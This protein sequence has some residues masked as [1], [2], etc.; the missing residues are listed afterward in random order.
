M[1]HQFNLDVPVGRTLIF[2]ENPVLIYG[3]F[4]D[5]SGR[6]ARA[7][8]VRNGRSWHVCAVTERLDVQEYLKRRWPSASAHVGFAAE[9]ETGAG[10]RRL[11]IEAETE[12]GERVQ[13]AQRLLWMKEYRPRE[14]RLALPGDERE[15]PTEKDQRAPGVSA[16][17][18]IAFYL[19]QF[20]AIPENDRWWGTGF[21]EWTN[22]RSVQPLFPGHYQPHQPLSGLGYYDLNDAGVLEK[23]AKLARDAGIFGFCFYYY[24]FAGK[25]LLEMPLERMLASGK[26]DMPFCYCWANENWSRRWDGRDT[27][28]LIAQQHSPADDDAVIHDLMRAFRDSRYIRIGRRPFLLVYRPKLIPHARDMFARWR[29]LCR[30]EGIGEIYLAGVMGF[31]CAEPGS[32][33]LDAL[34]EFPPNQSHVQ[35]RPP[36]AAAVEGFS[37]N[38]FD[39][40]EARNNSLKWERFPFRLFRGVTPSWDNTARRKKSGTIFTASSP[41]VYATWLER[42]VDITKRA[43]PETERFLFINAWNEWAEGCHLEPD[44][45][46]G[47]AWLNATRQALCG[48]SQSAGSTPP[49]SPAV[50]VIS[51]DAA[52]AGAQVLLLNLLKEWKRR[53]PFP[54]KVICVGDGVLRPQ[55]ENLYPTFVL[56]DFSAE[57]ARH[58]VLHEFIRDPLRIIYSSTVVNGPLL[59]GLRHLGVPIVTHSHEL[60]KSIERWAPGEIMEATLKNSDY[61]LAGSNVVAAN[62]KAR[63]GVPEDRLEVVFDF[64]ELWDESR[65]PSPAEL[66][67]LKREMRIGDADVVVFG[68]GTT[69]WRK[70]PDLFF[71]AAVQACK[72][73]ACLKFIWIGGDSSLHRD[74][75]AVHGLA[76]RIQFIG[77]REQSRRYYYVGHIFALT[78]REDPCPLVALEA[79]DAGLPVVCFDQAG[80]IPQVLGDECGAV[81]PLE[82][83]NAVATAI[84]ALARSPARRQDLGR[85]ARQRVQRG[86][87]SVAAAAALEKIFDRV[88]ARPASVVNPTAPA[89]LVSVIVP[90]YNHAKYLPERLRSVAGQT[91]T[92]IEIILLDDAS[93]DDSVSILREFAAND[94]RARLVLNER[95]SGST[96]KQ[97]RKGMQE[98]RGKY[99]WIAESDDMAEPALLATLVARLERDPTVVIACCQLRMMDAQGAIGATPDE[100]L[101][102]IHP[103]R[104]KAD[105]INDGLDEIRRCMCKKNTVLNASGVVFRNFKGVD[106]LVHDSIRLCGDWLFW[107]RL[108]ARGKIAYVA[109]PLNYWR[110]NTSNARTRPP[111][112]LEWKEGKQILN[113]AADLLELNVGERAAMVEAFHVRCLAWAAASAAG[114]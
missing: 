84:V 8:R 57:A 60:Q 32:F 21:T 113:E 6:P 31:G 103:T 24:W 63:H 9:V 99:V 61:F 44:V 82:D 36:P 88:T 10:L 54:V 78:S 94:R 23:Q 39:L 48:I 86:H 85:A 51:H 75:L 79:A 1:N 53:D 104:W 80:D 16:V 112:N 98:A 42:A 109:A 12:E 28:V 43:N 47:H 19:P 5:S 70:G 102:E 67:G 110:L 52:M 59:K 100:W 14:E 91:L 11:V 90:N 62:L 26:P 40:R 45:K 13:I 18:A 58:A 72:E 3:W 30:A 77:D 68:C 27:E 2:S 25:R 74:E 38:I 92:D 97:W 41:G 56:A 114:K 49:P 105:F 96:F 65:I 108:L 76:E 87:S 22:V 34:V 17:K 81:V 106:Q 71:K 33:G 50:L 7:V 4:A 83:V 101:E 37:G 66:A 20:H 107:I 15:F 89:P 46:Y 69:D 35:A 93:S 29:E 111:G 95:N 73:E 64:I 55:F